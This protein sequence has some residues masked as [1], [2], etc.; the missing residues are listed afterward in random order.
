MSTYLITG[1]NR[2]I[3]Y[4]LCKQLH[5]RGD[6]VLAV[7]RSSS[8]ELDGLGC[9]V[10]KGVDV[11]QDADLASLNEQL[12]DAKLDYLINNAGILYPGGLDELD[13]EQIREQLEIN[14]IGPLRVTKAL[15]P[16][17]DAGS[18]LAVV[19]SMMGS[20]TDNESGGYYGYRMSKAAVNS[21]FVSLS[22]DLASRQIPVAILHPGYVKTRMTGWN[23]NLTPEESARGLIAVLDKLT[24]HESGTFWHASGEVIPW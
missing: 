11:T 12:G 1:A 21:A 9:R 20:M 10:L 14:S 19:T 24:Q 18:K 3:G 2:G 13:F 6:E 15:L 5:E 17:L 8:D 4:E 23:G 7:C 22:K 16:R